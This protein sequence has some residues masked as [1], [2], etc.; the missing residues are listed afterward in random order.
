[1][2]DYTDGTSDTRR[3]PQSAVIPERFRV[4]GAEILSKDT[5][6]DETEACPSCG[7]SV[8]A[9]SSRCS[10]CGQWLERCSGSCPSCASPRCVGGKREPRT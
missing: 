2:P 10:A 9:D 5:W 4:P 8:D 7:R 1:M 3:S 6:D